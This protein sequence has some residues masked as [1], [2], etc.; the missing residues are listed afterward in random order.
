MTDNSRF[1]TLVRDFLESRNMPSDNAAYGL[2]FESE[3]VTVQVVA[4]PRLADRLIVD[5]V[6][7]ALEPESDGR[8]LQLLLE[9][10][11]GARFEHEWQVAIDSDSQ[12]IVH[13]WAPLDGLTLAGLEEFMIEGIDQAL[14]LRALV[15]ISE[16]ASPAEP[17]TEVTA[18]MSATP[19]FIR[20]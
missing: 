13:T 7:A 9:F 14:A 18:E 2:E 3:G 10:N 4:H 12:L 19:G 6:V 11:N 15:Q 17:D 8:L 16:A 1:D 20:G 5:A